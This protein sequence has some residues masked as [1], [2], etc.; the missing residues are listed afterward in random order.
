MTKKTL[1]FTDA[2]WRR[3][4]KSND[5][6]PRAGRAIASEAARHDGL[7]GIHSLDD[8]LDA[9]AA[10]YQ[11]AGMAERTLDV[12]Y[13]IWEDDLSGR[14]LFG[15]LL[16]A[17]RRGVRVR[18]LL[19]DNNTPGM[20]SI[21]SLLD[22]HPN[23]EIRLF[24][25]FSFRSLR[26][27]GYLTD[28]ARLNRRM[29]NKSFTV[30]GEVTIV[31]GRNVGDAYFGAGEQP[32]FT[33]LDVLAVGPVVADVCDD[34]ERYWSSDSVATLGQVLNLN[35]EELTRRV[36]LVHDEQSTP[37]AQRY[38][39]RLRTSH[40]VSQLESGQLKMIWARTRLLSDDPRKGEGKA[41]LRSLLGLRLMKVVGEPTSQLDITSAYFVPTRSGV[42]QLM[43]LARRGVK[44][45]ILTNSLA[46]NDVS[47]VHAGYARWRKKLLRAGVALF[48][49]K[50]QCS[51]GEVHDRGLTGNS[52]SSLHAKTFSVDGEKVFIGS[53]NFD[54][55]S[56]M[57]NTE[58]GFVIESQAL[59]KSIHERF[60]RSRSAAA[61]ELRLDK[62]RRINW[63][64]RHGGDEIVLKKEP[65][66]R[67]WQRLVV[68]IAARLPVE[69][70]L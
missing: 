2:C 44:V 31:G 51:P 47:A 49:L 41:R 57:L 18:M 9:F 46:A 33:D 48:E 15:A 13:Y 17:A 69:W 45:A 10:R 28:F 60:I 65:Q 11:L 32:L 39:E 59:A 42:A 37:M 24:N 21:L 20:D 50:P 22:S 56:A 58:M 53:F 30:D 66:T 62:W 55:R 61:W 7:S 43:M 3:P 52:G 40:F 19:D 27:L 38:L 35:D 1:D 67:F 29:H 26:M 16:D 23:I 6:A 36:E 68:R 63:I 5:R 54:P 70:L 4:L 25:P 64:E 14:L 34:F 12:Q 8:S